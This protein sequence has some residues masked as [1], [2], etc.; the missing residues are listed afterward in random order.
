MCT[1]E[2]LE[3]EFRGCLELAIY[4]LKTLG[5]YD[6]VSYRFSQWDPE[7]RD[8]YIGTPEQWDEAQSTMKKILDH[9]EIPYKIGIGEA[10]FYGPK[11]TPGKRRNA[12]RDS[13]AAVCRRKPAA[14][15][16]R[17]DLAKRFRGRKLYPV[18][19]EGETP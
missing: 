15:R 1:P 13:S 7:D 6:D 8:K 3:D 14:G 18:R 16:R 9:L 5:L 10:A 17:R 2:Q 4:M 12:R 11:G 19:Q